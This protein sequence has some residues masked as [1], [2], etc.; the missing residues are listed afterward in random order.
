MQQLGY[1]PNLWSP[2]KG[3]DQSIDRW[4]SRRRSELLRLFADQV[5]GR[6][7]PGGRIDDLTMDSRND[8]AL[9][10]SAIRIEADLVLVGPAGARTVSLLIYA[11]ASAAGHP[12]PAFLGLNFQGNHAISP[13]PDV[14]LA[15][16]AEAIDAAHRRT[17]AGR[18]AESRRWP[19]KQI[20]GRGY[21]VA[22]I[23]YE[24]LE[25]DLP[26]HPESGVRGLF[27]RGFER[28]S[29]DWGAI[30]AWAWGL[31]R[32]LDALTE[33]PEIDEQQV[34]AIGHS[35]L[36]KTA[37]WAA[38]QDQRFAGVISNESGCGGAS[39]FRH[40]SIEDIEVITSAR[41]H[42]FAPRFS[43]YRGIDE[44]LP[45]DQHQLL[46]LQAPRITHVGSALHDA[47]ADPTGEF[48]STLYASPIFE[49][50]GC[51]GTRPAGSD[52]A[53]VDQLL[54]R[55]A[56]IL[57]PADEVIGGR[58]SYHLRDGEHDMLAEDWKHILA[59][60]DQHLGVIADI[61]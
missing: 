37:L 32:A 57:P 44:Q 12:A 22:T 47:G 38:A 21:A 36:G 28:P 31:S 26:G 35:R 9:N 18:G 55:D 39:L 49:L 8:H 61:W 56:A 3:S 17:P 24:E 45:V 53:D 29:D 16:T 59:V 6:T 7:P 4:E 2:D 52:R 48:L 27:P 60:T 25:I 5:Y 33:I 43:D 34:V 30:G 14:R 40:H 20:L 58:L 13:E 50:Y 41:P 42:W 23:W 11:P 1:V 46:A 19:L 15:A 10:G 54:Q 51:Q